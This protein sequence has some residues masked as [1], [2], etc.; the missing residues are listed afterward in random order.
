MMRCIVTA[1]LFQHGLYLLQ[2][3]FGQMFDA[4]ELVP[5]CRKGAYQFVHF[6]LNG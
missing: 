4:D 6:R 2:F 3:C 5:C 1:F